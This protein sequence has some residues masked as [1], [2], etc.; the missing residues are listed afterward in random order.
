M[1][2][3]RFVRVSKV[4]A[5]YD[6]VKRQSTDVQTGAHQTVFLPVQAWQKYN[7]PALDFDLCFK[8]DNLQW[9]RQSLAVGEQSM[10]RLS[11]ESADWRRYMQTYMAGIQHRIFKQATVADAAQHDFMPWPL[12]PVLSATQPQ[13]VV[14]S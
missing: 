2:A 5:N 4:L 12:L 13:P 7:R 9:L 1:L 14:K 11:W 3:C 10:F 6:C 8:T